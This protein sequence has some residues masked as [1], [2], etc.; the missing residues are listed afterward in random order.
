MKPLKG[1]KVGV[2]K[3]VKAARMAR[4]ASNM[5]REE[6]V[7]RLTSILQDAGPGTVAELTDTAIAYWNGERLVYAF[8][9]AEGNGAQGEEFDLGA[10]RWAQWKDWLVDWLTDPL[11][12]VRHGLHHGT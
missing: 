11:L 3:D 5:E 6:F 4:E 10:Q 7:T 2:K 12:S 8:L 9:S 1:V